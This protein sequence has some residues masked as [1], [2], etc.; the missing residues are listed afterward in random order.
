M[1]YLRESASRKNLSVNQNSECMPARVVLAICSICV[2]LW[3]GVRL[4]AS[5]GHDTLDG[6]SRV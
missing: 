4:E 2:D 5:F 1:F 3:L 6:F